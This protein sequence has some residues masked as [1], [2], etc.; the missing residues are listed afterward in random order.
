MGY[1]MKPKWMYETPGPGSEHVLWMAA[2]VLR[3]AAALHRRNRQGKKAIA[4]RDAA[5]CLDRAAQ[6]E[7]WAYAFEL[8]DEQ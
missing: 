6:G 4:L 1:P 8:G 3:E 5:A 7:T 2:D